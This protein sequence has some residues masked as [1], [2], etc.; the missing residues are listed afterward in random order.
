MILFYA[1]LALPELKYQLYFYNISTIK[2][3]K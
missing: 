2:G 3:H 1:E